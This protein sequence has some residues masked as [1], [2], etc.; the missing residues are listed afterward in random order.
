MAPN[1]MTQRH[2]SLTTNENWPGT[3]PPSTTTTSLHWRPPPPPPSLPP[4][5]C[6]PNGTR[7]HF[8]REEMPTLICYS[9]GSV[10]VLINKINFLT[11]FHCSRVEFDW[12]DRFNTALTHKT[13]NGI[14][15]HQWWMV[16]NKSITSAKYGHITWSFHW[17][18][19]KHKQIST[20]K[21][22]N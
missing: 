18:L 14:S 9:L 17:T 21:Q 15:G 7:S 5:L 8:H 19:I 12:P 4:S 22:V 13:Q 11:S 6:C 1:T 16:E 10:P 3:P 2:V 20:I